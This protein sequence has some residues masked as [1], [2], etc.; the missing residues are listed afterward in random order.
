[1]MLKLRY[2]DLLQICCKLVVDVVVNLS[3]CTFAVYFTVD[4]HLVALV[5]QIE[6]IEFK[7]KWTTLR[8]STFCSEIF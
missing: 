1:M 3:C 2:F 8:R 5:L 4:N 7:R 6:L